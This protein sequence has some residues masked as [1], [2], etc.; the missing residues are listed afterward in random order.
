[1]NAL[2]FSDVENS[3]LQF[4]IGR[5]LILDRILEFVAHNTQIQEPALLL[6]RLFVRLKSADSI[7]EKIRRKKLPVQVAE[8]IPT[9]MDDIL[10]FR[11]IVENQTEL[12]AIDKFLAGAFEVK[13]I[14]T[15]PQNQQFGCRSIDYSLAYQQN[16]L[17]YHF[18]VQLRTFL[19]HYWAGHSFFLFH[20]AD[21]DTALPYQDDLLAL[22]DALQSAEHLAEKIKVTR[23]ENRMTAVP[24]ADWRSWPIRNRVHLMVVKPHEQFVDEQLILLRG[25][26]EDDHHTTVQSKM[27]CYE[28]YPDAAIVECMC[29]NFAGFLLNEPQVRVGS[30]HLERAVW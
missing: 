26:D 11:I 16:S 25:I 12:R 10:G 1:M 8:D 13:S 7:L 18:E 30:E 9:F 17:T 28:K 14:A 15:Q 4:R 5:R 29:A 27:S 2:R 3:L 21:S 20:K 22:S 19:Q 6:S 24:T 23:Q